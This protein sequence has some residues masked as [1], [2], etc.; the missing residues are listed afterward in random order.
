VS[1]FKG[2]HW[3]G[4][5]ECHWRKWEFGVGMSFGDWFPTEWSVWVMVGPLLAQGGLEAD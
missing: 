3:F 1:A 5:W 2:W 4:V